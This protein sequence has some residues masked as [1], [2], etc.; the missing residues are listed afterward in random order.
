MHKN[1]KFASIL[2]LFFLAVSLSLSA[3][4]SDQQVIQEVQRMDNAGMSQQ[5]I[6]TELNRR[7]VSMAQLQRIREIQDAD[8][9]DVIDFD[10][11]EG[12]RDDSYVPVIAAQAP[13]PIINP[14]DRDFG[15]HIF[16]PGNLTF[17]PNMNMPTPPNH[18]L[19]AGDELII[20]IWGHVEENFRRTIAPDG[21]IL[22]P[23]VGRVELM[24]LTFEQAQVRVK[25]SLATIYSDLVSPAPQT[26]MAMSLGNVRT[27]SVSVLGEVVAPGMFTVTS[28]TTVFNV[29]HLSGGPNNIGSLR[30]IHVTRNGNRVATIDLYDF[31]MHGDSSGDITLRDGDI[32]MVDPHGTLAQITGEVRRPM[33][34]EMLEN[35]TLEDLIRFAGGF[36]GNAFQANLSLHRRGAVEME[37]FTLS[38]NEF[39]TFHFR[40]GDQVSVGN[41][42]DRFANMVEVSGAVYRPGTFAIGSNIRTI[43]DLVRIAQGTTG[44]AHLYRVLLHREQD[45]L[46]PSVQ[47]FNLIDVLSGR[48]PDIALQANDRLYIPSIFSIEDDIMVTV[49]GEV[50][51]PGSFPFAENMHLE[52]LLLLA[53]GLT[54]AASTAKID[55]FRRQRDPASI[56]VPATVAEE[57][58]FSLRDGELTLR[59]ATFVLHPSD[60]VIVRRSPGYVE[61]QMITVQGEVLFSGQY[62]RISRDERLSSFIARAGGLTEYA[63]LQGASVLRLATADERRRTREALEAS[64]RVVGDTVAHWIDDLD[65]SHRPVAIDFAAALRNPGGAADII[66]QAGDIINVPLNPGTVEIAGG[67]LFPNIVFY[68]SRMNV[69]AYVRQAGGF[70]RLAMRNRVFVVHMNGQVST[71]RWATVT[72]GSIIV[73]PERP[74]RTPMSLQNWVGISTSLAT[75]ALLITR[76]L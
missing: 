3:Q 50:R 51:A 28:L 39:A 60:L 35:E 18:I 40:D 65:F 11:R 8:T 49:S 33:W 14:E 5:Q 19:G 56:T 17:A 62:A 47:A 72:P 63:F 68:S 36:T 22:L 61:Q 58:S 76:M 26:F 31:L 48:V 45:D 23:G 7:G 52:D 6:L 2:T 15:Q 69:N 66:L 24:G 70:S 34:Y 46:R 20:D 59:D 9:N 13:I 16:A 57:F 73:V 54:D 42:L 43:G 10:Q 67:V 1:H 55:V 25:N 27:I 64:A 41:I 53:G 29:L 32:I 30:N 75:V 71:G 4:M 38:E 44:D 74:P 12:F 37:A 21:H